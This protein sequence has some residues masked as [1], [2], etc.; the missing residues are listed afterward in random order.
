MTELKY[1]KV[2]CTNLC[3]VIEGQSLTRELLLSHSAHSRKAT[4]TGVNNQCAH[5]G[6]RQVTRHKERAEFQN[7][8]GSNEPK[9]TPK[10]SYL[11]SLT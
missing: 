9:V 8:T 7:K 4:R 2:N 11:T 6:E 5:K 10:K 3:L 1:N